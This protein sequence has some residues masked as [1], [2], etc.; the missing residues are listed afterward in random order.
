MVKNT[1]AIIPAAN[2]L[3]D[4]D[5]GGN[6]AITPPGADHVARGMTQ[7]LLSWTGGVWDD[8]TGTF[9]IPL[10]GGHTDYGGNEPY[11]IRL[12]DENPSWV[13]VRNPTGALGNT[14]ITRDGRE[15]TGLYFD[16][17]LRAV[18]SYNNQTFVPG[19]GPVVSRLAGCFYAAST[20][21]ANARAYRI[22][23][24]GE[25][26][27][28]C[29]YATVNNSNPLISS[30]DGACTYDPTRGARGTLWSLGNASSPLVQIDLASGTAMARGARDNHLASCDALHYIPG[31]DAL[32]GIN[33]GLLK[34]WP[35]AQGSYAP[36][37]PTLS[38]SFSGGLEISNLVGFGS[39]WAPELRQLCLYEN[40][41]ADGDA[42]G[43]ISTLT[44][45]AGAAA[46]WVRG[47][48]KVS[49]ANT[50]IPP[51]FGSGGGL[52]GRFG[53]SSRLRG[54]YLIMGTSH[55][56]YFFASE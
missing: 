14:G 16:G 27:L 6:P 50:V 11:R 8:D 20:S 46:P 28:I 40:G 30:H 2:T 32:A 4:I 43:E 18:H 48:L 35:L 34:I 3:A 39:C 1:W 52:F 15:A 44:P 9:W 7:G 42:R 47:V 29:D 53:Y 55:L 41:G 25:A 26:H 36:V 54:F 56:P 33:R 37:M 49:P 23:S 51:P 22:D 38:G 17:R 13:M 31:M 19:L 5:P 12:G 24:A 10:G 45:T 21:P